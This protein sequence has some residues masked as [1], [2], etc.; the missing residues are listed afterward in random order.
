M[1]AYWSAEWSDVQIM[2]MNMNTT[3][4][5]KSTH[6]LYSDLNANSKWYWLCRTSNAEDLLLLQYF[7]WSYK[8]FFNIK[9]KKH[10]INFTD[11]IYFYLFYLHL[12]QKHLGYSSKTFGIFLRGN[13]LIRMPPNVIGKPWYCCNIN[14]LFDKKNVCGIV[15]YNNMFHHQ[16]CFYFHNEN[17]Q[18][19]FYEMGTDHEKV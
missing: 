11:N 8:N 14:T 2:L 13:L 3:R 16:Y 1:S 17:F 19:I 12:F 5:E 7:Y 10:C 6:W 9:R 18:M 15:D 4:G